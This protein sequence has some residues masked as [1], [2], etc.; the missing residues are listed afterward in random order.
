MK[1]LLKNI[2]LFFWK[3]LRP[4]PEATPLFLMGHPRSGSSLLIHILCSNPKIIGFGEYLIKYVGMESF[5]RAEFDIRRKTKGLFSKVDYIANQVNH[6]SITPRLELI[7]STN[8]KVIFLIRSPKKTLSSMF[9]LSEKKNKPMSKESITQ[10]YIERLKHITTIATE[11]NKEQW[12]YITYSDLLENHK[13]ILVNLSTFLGL[14]ENLSPNYSLQ[15]FTQVWG[16][17]SKN[18]VEGKIMKTASQ[19]IEFNQ[20]LLEI[21]EEAYK[22]TLGYLKRSSL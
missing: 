22:N 11:I 7:K 8:S 15:K 21:A 4:K 13:D 12:R 5:L 19:Q 14:S 1:K 6:H 10:I 9:L 20:E 2:A 17:P 3:P 16:D 18:I